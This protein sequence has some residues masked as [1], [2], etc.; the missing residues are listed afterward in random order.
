MGIFSTTSMKIASHTEGT[1]PVYA[2]RRHLNVD[3]EAP[4]R[5]LHLETRAASQA[6][7]ALYT[8]LILEPLRCP[9]LSA[10]SM[11]DFVLLATPEVL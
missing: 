10:P 3:L 5:R 7:T 11:S 4:R 8:R 9:E 6:T 1:K 2:N